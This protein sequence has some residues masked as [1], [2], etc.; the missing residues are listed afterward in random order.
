MKIKIMDSGEFSHGGQDYS[1]LG[2]RMPPSVAVT[3]FPTPGP[4][5]NPAVPWMEPVTP[6]SLHYLPPYLCPIFLAVVLGAFR[7]IQPTI[8]SV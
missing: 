8:N 6:P 2:S 4:L 5:L 7:V 1:Q 3:V